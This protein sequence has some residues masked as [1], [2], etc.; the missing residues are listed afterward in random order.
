MCP[1]ADFAIA[2][3]FAC[4][5]CGVMNQKLAKLGVSV[6]PDVATKPRLSRGF[7]CLISCALHLLF[8]FQRERRNFP[9]QVCFGVR[10]NA[11][12]NACVIQDIAG[13]FH[14]SQGMQ[15]HLVQ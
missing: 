10:Q 8:R 4:V 3:Y 12:T 13:V 6:D 15:M 9:L 1:G 11:E 5:E 2:L 7:V 14:I